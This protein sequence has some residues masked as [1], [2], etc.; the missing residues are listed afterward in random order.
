MSRS[1]AVH[2]PASRQPKGF[3]QRR[4]FCV[5][6][7]VVPD[8]LQEGLLAGGPSVPRR[9][10]RA[11]PCV[12]QCKVLVTTAAAGYHKWRQAPEPPAVHTVLRRNRRRARQHV[13][14]GE[15]AVWTYE[16]TDL[17][18]D[19]VAQVRFSC[20]PS[21]LCRGGMKTGSLPLRAGWGLPTGWGFPGVRA[22]AAGWK[23]HSRGACRPSWP[24]AYGPFV[25]GS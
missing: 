22:A 4:T 13:I 11:D 18:C 7:V 12:Q 19:H 3:A 17:V 10:V 20:A 8:P 6:R 16:R 2:S 1:G 9:A 5:A 14:A 25:A 15:H 23:V 21:G 24:T